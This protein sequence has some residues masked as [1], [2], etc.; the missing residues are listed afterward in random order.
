MNLNDNY[1]RYIFGITLLE[2]TNK[3]IKFINL[4]DQSIL[5]PNS[6]KNRMKHIVNVLIDIVTIYTEILKRN[7][8]L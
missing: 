4:C 3:T 7:N 8:R 6:V 2:Y 1:S 5:I